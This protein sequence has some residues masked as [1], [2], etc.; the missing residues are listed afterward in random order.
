[1]TV[2]AVDLVFA[3]WV[4]WIRLSI[5]AVSLVLVGISLFASLED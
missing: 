4:L 2:T 1:M 5:F 3:L